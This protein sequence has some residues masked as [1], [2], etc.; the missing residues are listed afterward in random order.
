MDMHTT[1]VIAALGKCV[2]C[3]DIVDLQDPEVFSL[4]ARW[5]ATSRPMLEDAVHRDCLRRGRDSFGH[6]MSLKR[7]ASQ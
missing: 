3:D 5:D 1:Q 2:Y 7:R 4:V 6:A